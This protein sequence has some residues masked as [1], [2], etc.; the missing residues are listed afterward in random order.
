MLI[1]LQ[2]QAML[3]SPQNQ[4]IVN[5]HQEALPPS[6]FAASGQWYLFQ[7]DSVGGR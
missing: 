1:Y 6:T 2:N 4:A 3:I 7:P 5:I